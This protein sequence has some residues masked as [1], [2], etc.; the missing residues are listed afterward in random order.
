MSGSHGGVPACSSTDQPHVARDATPAA[1]DEVALS[2]PMRSN[3][4]MGIAR[5]QNAG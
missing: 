4:E 3:N 1:N 2:L 5:R